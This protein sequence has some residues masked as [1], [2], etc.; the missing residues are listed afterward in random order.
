MIVDH[1]WSCKDCDTKLFLRVD[2]SIQDMGK[3]TKFEAH[4]A[5]HVIETGH[6]VFHHTKGE[7][8]IKFV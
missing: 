6:E 1:K 8:K 4:I 5:K 2:D 3:L 7:V